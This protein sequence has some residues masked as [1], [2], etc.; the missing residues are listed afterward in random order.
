MAKKVKGS[1]TSFRGTT[2]GAVGNARKRQFALAQNQKALSG[3][4]KGG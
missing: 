4:G 2:G 1:G 3:S